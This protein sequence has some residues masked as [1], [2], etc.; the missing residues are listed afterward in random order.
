MASKTIR[1]S[2]SSFHSSGL[3]SAFREPHT[4]WVNSPNMAPGHINSCLNMVT[5]KSPHNVTPFAFNCRAQQERWTIRGI[6][7]KRS[8]NSADDS[9]IILVSGQRS[10]ERNTI[11]VNLCLA[12]VLSEHSPLG[13]AVSIV[14]N[15]NPREYERLWRREQAVGAASMSAAFDLMPQNHAIIVPVGNPVLLSSTP[16]GTDVCNGILKWYI[17]RF[18]NAFTSME[19]NFSK[20]GAALKHKRD[21]VVDPNYGKLPEVEFPFAP[22]PRL[23]VQIHAPRADPPPQAPTYVI[24]L[25]DRHNLV[26]E[27]QISERASQVAT[28]LASLLKNKRI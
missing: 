2:F 7:V 14:P 26:E 1:R 27:D 18:G 10:E 3:L 15:L 23:G 9:N 8:V 4:A 17:K 11:G 20:F 21:S 6:R 5:A 25:R 24:E 22:A 12:S 13:A 16:E 28:L 19:L